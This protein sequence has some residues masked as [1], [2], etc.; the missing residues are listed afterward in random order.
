[1]KSGGKPWENFPHFFF[2][3]LTLFEINSIVYIG[4]FL[5]PISNWNSKPK[6]FQN[7]WYQLDRT[8]KFPAL[9]LVK[10]HH[11]YITIKAFL[12]IYELGFI[13]FFSIFWKSTSQTVLNFWS[14]AKEWS[15]QFGLGIFSSSRIWWYLIL[16]LLHSRKS[17]PFLKLIALYLALIMQICLDLTC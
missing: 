17:Q 12:Y 9:V 3:I 14:Y 7:F 13:I 11:S 5:F 2:F 15:T 10:Y 4:C 16:L 1:M 6:G 8:V